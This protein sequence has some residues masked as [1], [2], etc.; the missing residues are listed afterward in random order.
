[1]SQN[2]NL[3]N[4]AF[5]RQRQM[6]TLATVAQILGIT[7]VALFGYHYYLQQQAG[8]LAAELQGAGGLPKSPRG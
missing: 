4:P 7:L 3:F 2:I 1:M 6:L 5:R 8:G